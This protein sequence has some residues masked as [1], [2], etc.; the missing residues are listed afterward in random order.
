MLGL[1]KIPLSGGGFGASSQSLPGCH[2]RAHLPFSSVLGWK[3]AQD[4][5]SQ[6]TN[7]V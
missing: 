3:K 6:V 2:G 1:T 7:H 5:G 4:Y